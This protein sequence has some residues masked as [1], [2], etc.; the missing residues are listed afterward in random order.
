MTLPTVA[1]G[2]IA[3]TTFVAGPA[4]AQSAPPAPPQPPSALP[5]VA[6]PSGIPPS[7]AP[8]PAARP[9]AIAQPPVQYSAAPP[10]APD[11]DGRH[12]HEVLD[13]LAARERIVRLTGAYGG[14]IAGVAVVGA[15]LVGET[16]NDRSYAGLYIVGG[17]LA[18]TGALG[19]ISRGPLET[20]SSQAASQSAAGLR[21]SWAA[22]ARSARNVR[23][24]AGWTG[25]GLGT[26]ALAG[27][28]A[29]AAGAGDMT[30]NQR[31]GWSLGL[32]ISG[33][34]IA[35]GSVG[36]L[37]I[38]S[39]TEMGYEAAY[40]APAPPY[41]VGVAPLPGGGAISVSGTF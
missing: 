20:L 21:D 39:N 4:L 36:T 7:P 37:F 12:A 41:S 1:V 2:A 6:G 29:I 10:I 28:T 17:T 33:A 16:Q 40:G 25:I 34:V 35:G 23:Q 11:D 14:M 15:G 32:L 31:A 38:P 22:M 9:E 30:S 13:A 8:S 19:L 26:A 24:F 3:L 27:G 5:P 18:L